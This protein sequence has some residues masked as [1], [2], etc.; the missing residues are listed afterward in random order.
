MTKPHNDDAHIK[1]AENSASSSDTAE[2]GN[3]DIM[4]NSVY[5]VRRFPYWVAPPEPHE[6]F[7]DIEWGVMEVLSDKT[8]RFVHEQPD[9]AELEKLIKHLES[10][11]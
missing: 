11:C 9:R 10:Q 6:T 1:T 7:R 4:K 3:M 2:K 8:L 5:V